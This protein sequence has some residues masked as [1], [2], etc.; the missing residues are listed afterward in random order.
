[1]TVQ[2]EAFR[3]KYRYT[4]L[5]DGYPLCEGI[6]DLVLLLRIITQLTVEAISSA[7]FTFLKK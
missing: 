4:L 1:M 2:F 5:T 3:V 7:G 6:N